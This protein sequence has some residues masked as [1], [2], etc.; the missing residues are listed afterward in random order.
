M[1]SQDSQDRK[2]L[3]LLAL[4]W[5]RRHSNNHAHAESWKSIWQVLRDGGHEVEELDRLARSLRN[6]DEAKWTRKPT[7][8]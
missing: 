1:T 3:I 5:L 6:E 7:G 2:S 8:V 4:K